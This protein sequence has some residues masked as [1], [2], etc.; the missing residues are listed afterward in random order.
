VR[1]GGACDRSGPCPRAPCSSPLDQAAGRVLGRVRRAAARVTA[2]GL[3]PT[4]R[5]CRPRPRRF[6]T[7]PRRS[8]G[9]TAG[10][11]GCVGLRLGTWGLPHRP[12]EFPRGRSGAPLSP[13]RG[14]P[15]G[16]REGL[17]SACRARLCYAGSVRPDH[18]A[19]PRGFRPGTRARALPAVALGRSPAAQA[20]R[21]WGQVQ[22]HALPEAGVCRRRRRTERR[23]P[24]SSRLQQAG[25]AAGMGRAGR[26]HSRHAP[27]ADERPTDY[28]HGEEH[29]SRPCTCL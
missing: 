22:A 29:A 13:A 5:A 23:H 28:R 2:P 21:P 24:F 16:R 20:C 26:R 27:G 4:T 10:C 6:R 17:L 19:G 3:P 9:R 1:R 15:A 14:I 25:C 7:G 18:S 11:A 8:T 12:A